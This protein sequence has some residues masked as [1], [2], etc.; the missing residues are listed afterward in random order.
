MMIHGGSQPRINSASELESVS[1]LGVAVL[2]RQLHGQIEPERFTGPPQTGCDIAELDQPR[3]RPGQTAD[4]KE[5]CVGGQPSADRDPDEVRESA[6]PGCCYQ[7]IPGV[8]IRGRPLP[9]SG[10]RGEHV[11]GW[12]HHAQDSNPTRQIRERPV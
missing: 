8:W 3:A 10:Q 9:V 12:S 1:R 4:I 6:L 11:Q 7:L 5:V 2:L